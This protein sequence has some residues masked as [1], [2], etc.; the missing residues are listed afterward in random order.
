MSDIYAEFGVNNA[1]F[2][3]VEDLEAHR[4]SMLAVD[5]DVRDGDDAI[6]LEANDAETVE[7]EEVEVETTEED[8]ESE[9]DNEESEQSEGDEEF[10]AIG[11]TP[12][13]L[14]ESVS[15]LSENEAAF[16]DMVS[17]AVEAGKVSAED[18]DAIKAEYEAGGK[19]SEASYAKLKEAGYTQRFVDSFIRGQEALAEQYA[20]QIV[21]MAGGADKFNAILSHLEANDKS[22]REAIESAIMRKD[23]A[24]AKALL[25]LSGKAM[26]KAKGV[27]PTRTVTTQGKPV[28]SKPAAPAA[29]GFKSSSEMV[30]AMRDPR[31][32]KDS[33]Y[34]ESVRAKVGASKF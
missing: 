9:T 29:E 10:E 6:R 4:Q 12:A 22:T 32:L 21:R 3:G 17:G 28:V 18:I 27:A 33:A 11:D 2:G 19:L 24:T 34:T 1:V 30:K 14:T 5:V 13:E 7:E 23:V 25:N 15:A 20:N 26:G 31:Y 8:S 16:D